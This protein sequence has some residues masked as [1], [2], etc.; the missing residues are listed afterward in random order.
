M[1]VAWGCTP[2]ATPDFQPAGRPPQGH[3]WPNPREPQTGATP[4]TLRRTAH[5]RCRETPMAAATSVT[6]APDRTARTA[7]N[8]CSTTDN[9]TS[10]NLGPP[11][12]RRPAE[13]SRSEGPG[14]GQCQASAGGRMSSITRHSTRRAALICDNFLYEVLQGRADARRGPGRRGLDKGTLAAAHIGLKRAGKKP[15]DRRTAYGPPPLVKPPALFA[16]EVPKSG[17][18]G[19]SSA[20]VTTKGGG[21]RGE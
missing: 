9:A 10:A 20:A 1:A 17:G 18:P 21:L 7:S 4:Y 3:K 2:A 11:H 13:R 16:R 8:R 19:A 6:V 14:T 15:P 12:Q 5:D